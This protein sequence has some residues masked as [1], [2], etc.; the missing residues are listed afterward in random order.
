MINPIAS[1][2]ISRIQ[3]A[4]LR[5]AIR[6]RQKKAPNAGTIGTNGVRNGLLNSGSALRRI[7]TPIHTSTNANSVPILVISPRSSIGRNPAAIA[8][9]IPVSVVGRYGV[10]YFGWILLNAGGNNPSR[11]TAKNTRD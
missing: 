2:T 3:V 10:R 6:Y 5:L 11:A 4:S 9:A 1:H 7:Q 8:T